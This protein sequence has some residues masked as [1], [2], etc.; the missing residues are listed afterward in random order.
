[1]TPHTLQLTALSIWILY[2]LIVYKVYGP[3]KSV[4]ASF[5]AGRQAI[6]FA[7]VAMLGTVAMLILISNDNTLILISVV[8]LILTACSPDYRTKVEETVHIAGASGAMAFGFMYLMIANIWMII[9]TILMIAFS[10]IALQKIKNYT[11]WI[12]QVGFG[13]IMISL[14]T[15]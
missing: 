15:L 4:S 12:E 8:L 3:L 10:L 2:S 13:M 11:Y 1:M 7:F 9:P 6:K 5:Y 14:L